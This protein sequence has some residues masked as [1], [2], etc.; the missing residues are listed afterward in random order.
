MIARAFSRAALAV[1]LAVLGACGL[2]VPASG[3][4][5][6]PLRPTPIADRPIDLDGTCSQTEED[7]FHESARLLVRGNQVQALSWQMRIGRRGN[8]AFE[9][10]SFRQTRSRPH[11]ELAERDG[12]GCKLMIWQDPRRITMGH[13]GCAKHCTPGIYDNAWP[14]MFDPATGRCAR[15]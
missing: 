4:G 14:V 6:A 13:A 15:P 8:C 11:V 12:S 7:G 9:L 2:I 10:A 3:P 5:T 1:L